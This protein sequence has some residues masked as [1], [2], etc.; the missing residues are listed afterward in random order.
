MLRA[1]AT[2]VPFVRVGAT[3][4]VQIPATRRPESAAPKRRPM[5]RRGDHRQPDLHGSRV[6]LT[7]AALTKAHAV[8]GATRLAKDPEA[9]TPSREG[10]QPGRTTSARP[11]IRK[12]PWA[13][14]LMMYA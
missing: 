12:S 1:V 9:E 10:W 3:V 4:V 6:R 11:M 14:L 13:M 5:P 7:D 8:R 2:E